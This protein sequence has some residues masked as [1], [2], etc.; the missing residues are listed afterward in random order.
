MGR[1]LASGVFS[2]YIF[3]FLLLSANKGCSCFAKLSGR[4]KA[5][6]HSRTLNSQL[7]V[8]PVVLVFHHR[9]PETRRKTGLDLTG[10]SWERLR[11]GIHPSVGWDMEWMEPL[12]AIAV[13]GKTTMT[14]SNWGSFR[15][16]S[17]GWR[18]MAMAMVAPIW[19]W[20]G[21]KRPMDT[22]TLTTTQTPTLTPT[23]STDSQ[24]ADTDTT[25]NAFGLL[26]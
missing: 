11:P 10:K 21:T 3:C 7:I 15:S 8:V 18:C 4:Q 23:P 24:T 14:T 2:F 5:G 9:E 25:T 1:F 6:S 12:E 22:N 17:A 19:W 20:T 26:K 13:L 16:L